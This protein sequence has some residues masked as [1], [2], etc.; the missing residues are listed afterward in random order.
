M[1]VCQLDVTQPSPQ[2]IP[3]DLILIASSEEDGLA[4]VE[5]SNIDGETNLKLKNSVRLDKIPPHAFNSLE[6]FRR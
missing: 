2:E 1:C 4:F 5:T 3:A 6:T